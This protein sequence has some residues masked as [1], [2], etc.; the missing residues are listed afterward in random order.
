M[1]TVGVRARRASLA[2]EEVGEE[3]DRI[4]DGDGGGVSDVG[5]GVT[6]PRRT[7]SEDRVEDPKDVRD[8]HRAVAVR[9]AAPEGSEL[10]DGPRP[11]PFGTLNDGKVIENDSGVG[12]K[13]DV[14]STPVEIEDQRAILRGGEELDGVTSV[15][16][17][18]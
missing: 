1:P 14:H 8:V 4:V 3:A 11:C 5:G 9:V 6:R 18:E 7:L 10:A 17:L 2:A 12:Q 15:T 13:L 16:V